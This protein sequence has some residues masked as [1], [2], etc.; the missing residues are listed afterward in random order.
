MP[1]NPDQFLAETE[2][3]RMPSQTP[4]QM[5]SAGF[6]PDAFLAETSGDPP[7]LPVNDYQE[8]DLGFID[9]ARY[10]IEPIQSNRTALLAQEFGEENISQDAEGNIY[11]RQGNEFR[12]INKDSL[13]FTD[14]ADF[15]GAIPEMAGGVVG[16]LAGLFGGAVTTGGAVSVPAAVALGAA[17]AGA[18]SAARQGLSAALGTPQVATIGERA[19]ETGTSAAFGGA[20]TALGIGAK[21]AFKKGAPLVQKFLRK[22]PI[23]ESADDVMDEAMKKFVPD[24]YADRVLPEVAD[25][26]PREL[27]TQQMEKLK[28]IAAR[29]GLP[30]PTYAQ[31]AGGKAILAEAKLLDTPLIGG[32][33]RSQ[34]DQQL[35]KVQGNLEK[36]AGKFIDADST[37]YEVGL[38]TKEVA[39]TAAKVQKQMATELYSKID[40]LGANATIGKGQFFNKYRDFAGELG[41]INPD[42]SRAKYAADSGLTR[43]SFNQ[44]QSAVFDGLDAIQKTKSPKIKFESINALRR[45]VRDTA[46]ELASK[47][48][49]AARQLKRFAHE[50]EETAQRSLNRESPKLGEVFKEANKNYAKFKDMEEFNKAIFTEGMGEERIVKKLMSDSAK[51]EKM[52]EVIGED[53]VKEIGVSFVRDIL[54]PLSKSG[55]A[56]ADSALTV[57]KKNAPQI[58]ASIGEDAYQ[59]LVD[60]LYYLNRVNQPLNVSRTSLYNLFDNNSPGLKGLAAN[61]ITSGKT[62]ATSKG[63]GPKDIVMSPVRKAYS[64]ADKFTRKIPQ[65]TSGLSNLLGD[66]TQRDISSGR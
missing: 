63:I 56:R 66:K 58:R 50:I 46:E 7:P 62:Y 28:G 41:L 12:P 38:A 53:K 27:I 14:V 10:S 5:Q 22:A 31:A 45:T 15:A 21:Q 26:A 9:R 24:Q 11:L 48:P 3:Q 1:F 8:A 6:D 2:V 47:N 18:G 57:I 23:A 60:N 52:K 33:V 37:A 55:V 25:D 30:E 61:V 40:E 34:V 44:L 64:G 43:E 54:D 29:Q 36:I 39:N 35:K 32:K 17:G 42:L 16:G 59:S 4:E 20:G 49:S 13:S 19:L 65:R 51:I